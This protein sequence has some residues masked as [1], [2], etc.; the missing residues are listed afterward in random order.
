MYSKSFQEL[1]KNPEKICSLLR[2]SGAHNT[3]LTHWKKMRCFI[4]K[5]INKDGSI[6]DVGCGNGFLLKCLQE[7]SRFSLEPY[8]LDCIPEFIEQAKRLF[9][10]Q[11]QNFAIADVDLLR[12][13]DDF[14][15]FNLPRQYK[16]IYWNIWDNWLF[17]KQ[18]QVI[19]LK[20]LF[21]ALNNQGRLIL[22]FYESNNH[23][24]ET[25]KTIEFKLNWK[26]SGFL[27]VL[28]EDG[29]SE[30]CIWFDKQGIS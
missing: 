16:F 29:K 14:L 13:P 30:C 24:R 25:I 11:A 2:G 3:N 21:K 8:G 20:L 9:P 27:E 28:V 1:I 15:R 17:E 12:S 7:W 18:E 4:V 23:K 22:G 6:L 10:L 5:A 26:F 19:F